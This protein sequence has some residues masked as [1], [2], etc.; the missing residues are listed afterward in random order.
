MSQSEKLWF[1]RKLYGWGWTPSSW[2]GW[3]S[4][5][6][7]VVLISL[8]VMSREEYIPGNDMSGSNFLTFALP[9]FLLTTFFIIL[10]FKKGEK[11]RWQWGKNKED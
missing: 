6:V 9:I 11:P 8:I 10:L 5:I 7:Y 2:Q 3:V 4:L 1:K